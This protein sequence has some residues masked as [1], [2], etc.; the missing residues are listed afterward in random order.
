MSKYEESLKNLSYDVHRLCKE[1]G[2]EM[3]ST[4]IEVFKELIKEH[5]KLKSQLTLTE[6][7]LE[8]AYEEH[9][10][11]STPANWVYHINKEEYMQY[12]ETK[13]KEMMKS[14]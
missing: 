1:M 4:D 5:K 11:D 7:A 10:K 8:L 13:A 14:E 9:K 3:D 6:K 12:L 2:W